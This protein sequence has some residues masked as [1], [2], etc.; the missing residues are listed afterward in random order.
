[1]TAPDKDILR[2]RIYK[3]GTA[4]EHFVAPG[5]SFTYGRASDNDL[6]VE[7][8]EAPRRQHLVV[9]AGKHYSLVVPRRARGEVRVGD[10]V[11]QIPDLIQHGLLTRRGEGYL[12]PIWRGKSGTLELDGFRV[13][14]DFVAP[15]PEVMGLPDYSWRSQLRKA[16]TADPLLKAVFLTLL[17]VSLSS[18]SYVKGL[19]F[20]ERPVVQ[21]EQIPQRFARFIPRAMRREPEVTGGLATGTGTTQEESTRRERRTQG[22]ETR[23]G[24]GSTAAVVQRGILGLI[25]GVGESSSSSSV[26]EF[27]VGSGLVRE[28]EEVLAESG[29]LQLGRPNGQAGGQSSLDDLLRIGPLPSIDVD[30]AA[31]QA[32]SRI[33]NVELK[34]EGMVD[35][36]RAP[37]VTGSSEAIGQRGEEQLRAVILSNRSR[38][39]YVYNKYLRTNPSLAGKIVLEITI[40]PDGS[41]SN[42][43]VLE[44]TLDDLAFVNEILSIVRRWRFPVIARGVVIVTYP[45]IFYRAE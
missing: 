8:A 15:P 33:G 38:I 34:K 25:G 13:E 12:L 39:E 23:E 43:R 30:Q 5:E 7:G 9:S 41:V 4:R 32:T 6:V 1:M 40:E 24:G 3:D 17:V 26:V 44:N 16:V 11:L 18:V 27:L 42:V 31:N 45:M 36:A 37:E 2:L 10:S 35:L 19:Q 28:M 20:P 14:Y 29:D 22:G 21:V